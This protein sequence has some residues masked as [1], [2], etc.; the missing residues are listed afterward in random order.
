MG[1]G[2]QVLEV[3][4]NTQTRKISTSEHA[5]FW[6]QD[7]EFDEQSNLI[8]RSAG[9]FGE[10]GFRQLILVPRRLLQGRLVGHS[11]SHAWRRIFDTARLSQ[12][13]G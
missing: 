5:F 8:R 12:R 6:L 7:A 1:I 2:P 4:E 9:A 10:L 13:L 11:T 3:G